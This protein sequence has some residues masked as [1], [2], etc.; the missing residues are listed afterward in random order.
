MSETNEID[1]SRPF[2]KGDMKSKLLEESVF[3]V[4]FP[5]Y[6]EK[7][8]SDNWEKIK[9][10]LDPLGIKV[11]VDYKEGV[12]TVRT[13]DETWDPVAILRARDAMKLLARSVP[14]EQAFRVLQDGID[15]RILIIGKNIRN[16]ERFNKRR[17]RLLGPNGSTLK[18]LELLT[19]CY[20]LVQGHTVA[21][22]GEARGIQDATRVVLDCMNNIHPVYHIK[23]LMVKRELMSNPDMAHEDWDRYLPK[24]KKSVK[25]VKKQPKKHN[26]RNRGLPDYPKDSQ[27]DKDIESGAY[28]Y[29]QKKTNKKHA[30]KAAKEENEKAGITTP[31]QPPKKEIKLRTVSE[32]AAEE[33]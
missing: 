4:L 30:D 6:R 26:E 5:H 23:I 12:L 8:L 21:I 15:S 32:A 11:E 3:K 10:K 31:N 7:Y 17:Q 1:W 20:I 16:Q 27:I 22:I 14:I 28:F 13:T 18:A 29:K 9:G 25:Q 2:Q 24:I 19:N 33:Q